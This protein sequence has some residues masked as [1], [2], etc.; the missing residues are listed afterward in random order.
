M[1]RR[2]ALEKG[3]VGPAGE[4]FVLYQLY[5]RGILAALAPPGTPVVDL[6]VL[7]PHGKTIAA[8]LQVKTRTPSQ[9]AWIMKDKHEQLVDERMFYTFV[10]LG[11]EPPV[12]W[13]VP[14]AVVAKV[15]REE[16]V[17]WLAAPGRGGRP[18]QKNPMRQIRDEYP[19]PVP[20]Y[21]AGWMGSYREH[22]DLV[23]RLAD[24]ES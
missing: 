23:S 7:S 5:R 15:V 22:W 2:S 6:L 20:G 10:D 13:I 14:S 9:R 18:H 1:A 16:H 21:P 11:Q 8:S 4:H 17:A 24:G 12:T 3:L 19:F